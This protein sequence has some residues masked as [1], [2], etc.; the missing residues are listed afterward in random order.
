MQYK[1]NQRG[2]KTGDKIIKNNPKSER[3][4]FQPA[5]WKRFYN[6]KE[7]KEEESNQEQEKLGIPEDQAKG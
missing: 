1:N 2:I 3:R 6:V 7:S 5:D 4:S